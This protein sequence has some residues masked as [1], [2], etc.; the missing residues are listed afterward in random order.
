MA[1]RCRYFSIST[2]GGRWVW[3]IVRAWCRRTAVMLIWVFFS[4]RRRAKRGVH[5]RLFSLVTVT[6]RK[7]PKKH[8]MFPADNTP[9][10]NH[11]AD[12][13][14][15][16]YTRW[17]R[18]IRICR[19]HPASNWWDKIR[20]LP[21]PPFH[22]VEVLPSQRSQAPLIHHVVMVVRWWPTHR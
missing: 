13:P 11:Q 17:N 9:S 12:N 16:K 18:D 10:P 8:T 2:A 5:P 6:E 15:Y 7:A 21:A 4:F 20:H 22:L 1:S 14:I 19:H 3:K